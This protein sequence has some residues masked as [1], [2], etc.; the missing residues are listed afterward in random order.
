MLFSLLSAALASTPVLSGSY[1]VHEE[2]GRTRVHTGVQL[3]LDL[4]GY[5]PGVGATLDLG[6]RV[7][8]E[9]K[10]VAG[11]PLADGLHWS[12]SSRL[13]LQLAPF[14]LSLGASGDLA[15]SMGAGLKLDGT[16]AGDVGG[17]PWTFGSW[18]S[19]VLELSPDGRWTAFGG[20][21]AEDPFGERAR[22]EPNLGVRV[23]LD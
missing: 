16:L 13:G 1:T 7:A 17:E 5:R 20:V 12:G 18:F 23:R 14:E 2:A 19:S 4:T 15:L 9:G 6:H 10:V 22:V 3:G 8:V 11:L 21:V